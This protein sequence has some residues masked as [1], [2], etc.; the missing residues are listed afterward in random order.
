MKDRPNLL[1]GSITK[2]IIFLAAPMVLVMFL[3]TLFN[4]VDTIF[5]GRISAYAVAAVSMAFTVMFIII[6]IGAGLGIG[7]ASVVARRLGAKDK[8]GAELAAEHSIF[9]GLFV[10]LLITALGLAF[11]EQIFILMG[12]G[13]EVLPLV[14]SYVRIL[15]VGMI[16]LVMM[17]IGNSILQGEGDTKTPMKI[18]SFAVVLNIILDPIFIFVLGYGVA[19]AAIATVL[20]RAVGAALIWY[21]LL[22]NRALLQFNLRAFKYAPAIVRDILKVGLPSMVLHGAMGVGMAAFTK[23]SSLFGPFAIAAYGIGFRLESI[24]IL[25]ALG[26]AMAVVT[27]VGQNVG[28]GNISRAKKTTWVAAAMASAF[29][30]I[31]A[32]IIS[33]IPAQTIMLFNSDPLVVEYGVSFIRIVSASFMLTTLSIVIINAFQGAGNGTV[34]LFLTLLRLFIVAVPLAYLLSVTFGYGLVG[35]WIGM[36]A[37]NAVAGIVGA[38][39][40]KFSKFEH[41]R[42]SF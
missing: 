18:I 25:P 30:V 41:S 17:F 12:A 36:A 42:K 39:W 14:L 26:I 29:A 2:N 7:T 33:I 27:I 10:S 8:K 34:P 11:A 1:E 22:S 6:A 9:I 3:Q 35:V 23:L 5:V 38:I 16:F 32:I 31:V 37:S 28:A 20:S 13:P 4:I 15:F 40:F 21:F 24:A 19:G